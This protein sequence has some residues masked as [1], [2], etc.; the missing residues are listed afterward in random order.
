MLRTQGIKWI[1]NREEPLG[2]VIIQTSQQ[3]Y[4][5]KVR[6]GAGCALLALARMQL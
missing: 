3:K 1:I 4:I 2:L 6:G 5:D